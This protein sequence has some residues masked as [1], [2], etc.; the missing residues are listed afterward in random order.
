MISR[1]EL[2]DIYFDKKNVNLN[3]YPFSL[4]FFKAAEQLKIHPTVTFLVGENGTGKSTLLEAIAVASGFNPE[5][6]AANF[7][8]GTR[9][10]HSNLHQHIT[11]SR[12]TYR[13]TDGYFL[14]S[15]SLFNV[16]TE[17]EHLDEG[18]GGPPIIEP[19]AVS[20]CMNNRTVNHS[21]RYF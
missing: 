8:F 13:H 6:G 7:N 5:G 19:M 20:R 4:P 14:R 17:I 18:E 16:A 3:T 2:K 9:A 15:E 12:G 1:G 21:G 11:T 10:S